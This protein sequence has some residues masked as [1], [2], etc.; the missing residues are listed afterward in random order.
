MAVV[1]QAFIIQERPTLV[2]GGLSES[3]IHAIQTED[4]MVFKKIDDDFVM[5]E[6]LG[7]LES[8]IIVDNDPVL[9]S[10]EYRTHLVKALFYKVRKDADGT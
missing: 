8:E 9:A 7:V 4:F 1:D 2:F 5:Q 10:A 6:A 3:F